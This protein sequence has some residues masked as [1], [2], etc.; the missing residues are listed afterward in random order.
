M[1]HKT[2]PYLSLQLWRNEMNQEINRINQILPNTHEKAGAIREWWI[3]SVLRKIEQL[4]NW[5]PQLI[6]GGH[7]NTWTSSL[8]GGNLEAEGNLV[9]QEGARTTRGQRKRARR[10]NRQERRVT[11]GADIIINNVLPFLE[12]PNYEWRKHEW[13]Y[14]HLTF[15]FTRLISSDCMRSCLP[16][17]LQ[18]MWC[19]IIIQ[20]SRCLSRALSSQSLLA[21]TG[22]IISRPPMACHPSLDYPP[23]NPIARSQE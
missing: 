15:L 6:E 22:L 20:S 8:G 10:K 13:N 17:T 3:Q 12:L 14:Y 9:E 18:C 4:Q 21:S 16:H 23:I 2:I 7:N 1:I 5:A 19:I 11:C